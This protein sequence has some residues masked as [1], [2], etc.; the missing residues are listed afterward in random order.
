MRMDRRARVHPG[1]RSSPSAILPSVSL[2]PGA[3]ATSRIRRHLPVYALLL[4]GLLLYGLWAG[5]PLLQ[6]F[7]MSFTDWRLRGESHFLGLDNYTRALSD[8]MFWKALWTTVGYTAVT[9]AGQLILG[10]GAA[11]LLN[12]SF[13]GRSVLRLVYYLP[14]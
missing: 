10:L 14:V 4:P 12:Q 8:P 9:V 2:R 7:V 1:R 3:G 5:W 6:S 13:R 11:L